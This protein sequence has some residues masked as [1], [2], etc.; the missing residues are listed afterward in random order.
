M[1]ARGPHYLYQLLLEIIL[2]N[3]CK[4]TTSF[5]ANFVSNKSGSLGTS[6]QIP[7]VV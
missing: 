1:K 6:V 5:I 4:L 7:A 3:G 2:Q